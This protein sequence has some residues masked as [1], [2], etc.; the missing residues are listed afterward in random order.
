MVYVNG[1]SFDVGGIISDRMSISENDTLI[2]SDRLI[3]ND[4][5]RLIIN[6]NEMLIIDDSDRLI[7]SHNINDRLSLHLYFKEEGRDKERGLYPPLG[8][9]WR[10]KGVATS[11]RLDPVN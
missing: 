3:I 5:D 7:I 9:R 10:I 6:D 1:S 4:N 2:V 8:W 11:F